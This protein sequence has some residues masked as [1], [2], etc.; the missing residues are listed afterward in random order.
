MGDA[1]VTR[2]DQLFSAERMARQFEDTYTELAALPAAALGW[3]SF[4]RR[5]RPY[6]KLLSNAGRKQGPRYDA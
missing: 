3:G 2:V 5:L 4:M 6:G 1:A